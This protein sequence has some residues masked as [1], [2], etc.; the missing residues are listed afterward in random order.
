MRAVATNNVTEILL[1]GANATQA[2]AQLIMTSKEKVIIDAEK[3]NN[4][5]VDVI[6][7]SLSILSFNGIDY[8]LGTEPNELRELALGNNIS[9]LMNSDDKFIQQFACLHGISVS[10]H[11]SILNTAFD[12]DEELALDVINQ[13]Q[14]SSHC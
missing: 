4:I 13:L 5:D 6:E 8:E 12:R 11:H 9:K 1:M 7:Q 14:Q 3:L 10:R 2:V